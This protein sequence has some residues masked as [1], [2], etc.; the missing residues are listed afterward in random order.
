[1]IRRRAILMAGALLA[2]WVAGAPAQ[3]RP[4]IAAIRIMNALRTSGYDCATGTKTWRGVKPLVPH[5]KLMG[6]ARAHSRDMLTAG[7]FGHEGSSGSTPRDRVAAAKFP[8]SSASENIV[9]G[10]R[11]GA[12][13]RSAVKW[14]KGSQVHCRNMM[15]S[16]F[17]HVGLAVVRDPTDTKGIVNYWTVVFATRRRHGSEN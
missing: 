12:N 2:G 13:A 17:T 16:A 7:F 5:P 4:E 3:E 1:V 10:Q 11:V 6:A 8:A 14:W 15:N 9:G